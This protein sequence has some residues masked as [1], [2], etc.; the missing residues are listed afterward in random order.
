MMSTIKSQVGT[1]ILSL[2]AGRLYG[3]PTRICNCRTRVSEL[4]AF[5]AT[6]RERAAQNPN[7]RWP[8]EAT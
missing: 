5:D 2:E 3:E 6:P 8:K 4:V 7:A 1:A